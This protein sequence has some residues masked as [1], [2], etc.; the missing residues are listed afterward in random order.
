MAQVTIADL[1]A[2]LPAGITLDTDYA[3][4]DEGL[5]A[6]VDILD[7]FLS[8]QAAVND[9]TPA[10]E[11]VNAITVGTGAAQTLERPINSGTFI[12]ATPKVFTVSVFQQITASTNYAP[13]I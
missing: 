7:A 2:A 12:Q 8:A 6:V 4:T 9:G 1:Q 10:G 11:A 3:S 13:L 5:N